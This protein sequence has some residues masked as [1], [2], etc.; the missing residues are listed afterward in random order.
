MQSLSLPCKHR[1]KLGQLGAAR[2]YF[3]PKSKVAK[4]LAVT[5]FD[6]TARHPQA[7]AK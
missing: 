7:T 3:L 4:T 6:A 2:Y 5:L 1:L